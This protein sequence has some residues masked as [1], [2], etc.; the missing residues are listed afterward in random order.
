MVELEW[1][2]TEWDM[3]IQQTGSNFYVIV[4]LRK[5]MGNK[6][7]NSTQ[8]RESKEKYKKH[9]RDHKT[10]EESKEIKRVN[11]K[12]KD[13]GLLDLWKTGEAETFPQLPLG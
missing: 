12:N 2:T 11:R 4:G 8:R 1:E 7:I 9:K 6:R 13:P 5:I 3:S 10:A